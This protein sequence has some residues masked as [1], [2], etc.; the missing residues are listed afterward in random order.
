MQLPA[1]LHDAA[2]LEALSES[3]LS[4]LYLDVRYKTGEARDKPAPLRALEVLLPPPAA[5]SDAAE[6]ARRAAVLSE[7]V[8]LAKDLV[9]APANHVTPT[10]LARTAQTVAQEAGLKVQVGSAAAAAA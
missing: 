9:A 5:A 8:R 3:L 4:G 6:A 2:A 1:G 7:A 10:E